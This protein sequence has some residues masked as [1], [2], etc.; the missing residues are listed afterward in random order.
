[1]RIKQVFVSDDG[2]EFNTKSECLKHEGKYI[3]PKCNGESV[4]QEKYNAYPKN[5]PDSGWVDDW[6]YRPVDCDVCKGAGYTDKQLKPVTRV[7]G[8]E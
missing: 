2:K 7:V 6:K 4:I 3:C 1:M 8:Y 5:L